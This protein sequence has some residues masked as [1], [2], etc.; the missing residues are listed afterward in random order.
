MPIPNR[1]NRI[2]ALLEFKVQSGGTTSADFEL[3]TKEPPRA[4]ATTK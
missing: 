2:D 4:P 3:T 1:Y